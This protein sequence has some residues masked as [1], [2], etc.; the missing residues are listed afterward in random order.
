MLSGGGPL[1]FRRRK[2]LVG[3]MI[4]MRHVPISPAYSSLMITARKMIPL[5]ENAGTVYRASDG[6]PGSLA[7]RVGFRVAMIPEPSTL[8]LDALGG[9][10]LLAYRRR[11]RWS[12]GF[13]TPSASQGDVSSL[14]GLTF[15]DT[16]N[17]SF[18]RTLRGTSRNST[19][20]RHRSCCRKASDFGI[21]Q[22]LI[23]RR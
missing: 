23:L 17:V 1:S 2:W 20:F 6:R 5:C 10:A 11:R 16:M 7:R 9:L 3:C 4:G 19:L 13:A 21:L 8:A 15:P 12:C 18:S 22:P 14:P